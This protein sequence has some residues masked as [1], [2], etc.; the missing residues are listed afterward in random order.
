MSPNILLDDAL[1]LSA[2]VTHF[3]AA[4]GSTPSI[5]SVDINLGQ[6]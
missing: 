1:A 4:T 5:G 3:C 6:P 2:V